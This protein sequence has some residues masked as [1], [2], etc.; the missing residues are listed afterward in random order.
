MPRLA[1][2]EP[3]IG[4][5]TSH[6][7]PPPR[8]CFSPSS[9]ETS[10]NAA[11]EA[12]SRATTARSAASSIAVV[13]SPPTPSPTTGSRSA[14]P[15]RSPS[16]ARTSSTAPRQAP[17]Q[18][19]KRVEQQPR[20]ELGS[21]V[22][23]LL[24]QD[25][26]AA[27]PLEDVGNE[28]RAH[29]VGRLGFAAVD[30]RLGLIAAGRVADVLRPGALDDLDVQPF[31]FEQLVFTFPVD[32]HAGQL[33]GWALDLGAPRVAGAAGDAVRRLDHEARVG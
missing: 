27:R 32:N 17:S 28:R 11:P 21:E 5:T 31:P 3:S 12:S 6:G 8:T 24:R 13:S 29:E 19:V 7:G 30:G 10:V 2:S 4:S 25:L 23:R 15:G 18:S 16:T 22:G 33:V 20:D 9:S 26:A 14:R 1:F